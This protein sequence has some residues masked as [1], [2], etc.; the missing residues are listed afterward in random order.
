V[1]HT[2]VA[3]QD[4]A[5]AEWDVKYHPGLA[6][7]AN[8]TIDTGE[9]E[10]E[11]SLYGSRVAFERWDGGSDTDVLYATR[12][13]L[14]SR[15]AGS[16]RYATAAMVSSSYFT[17][18]KNVVLCT[19]ENFPDALAAGPLAR[20]LEAPL[21]LTKKDSLPSETISEITRLGATKVFIIGGTPTISAAVASQVDAMPGVTIER[22]A[23]DDRYETSA[24]IARRVQT[25]MGSGAVFRAVFTRGDNF[26]DALSVGPVAAGAWA[27]I[28]LVRTTSV[29]A[30]VRSAVDDMNITLGFVIGDTNS[31]DATTYNSIRNLIIANGAVGTIA[32]RWAGPN[33]Y[34]TASAVI[35]KGLA[36]RWIDLDTLGVAVGTKFPDALGGGAAL[37]WYGSPIILTDGT[38]LSGATSAF[39]IA[40]EYEIGR[41]DVYGDTNSVSAGVYD[42]IAARMK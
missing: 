14:L 29:P 7:F 6:L 4:N 17:K 27:P 2:T 34:E 8:S 25:I 30:S 21:L 19:G 35:E 3:W 23:G 32:E 15:T 18:A 20:A 10:G 41:L 26:P 38:S 12:S 5:T 28:F 22:I 13:K 24:K 37:G 42:A 11:V 16:N 33:R 31:V 1:F 36:N 40:H 39:L 9:H